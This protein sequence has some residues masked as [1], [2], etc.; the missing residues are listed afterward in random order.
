MKN[1]GP[2]KNGTFRDTFNSL[3]V[4]EHVELKTTNCLRDLLLIHSKAKL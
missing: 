2:T 1:S 4:E 3:S